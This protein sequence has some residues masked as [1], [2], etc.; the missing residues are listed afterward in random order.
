M[1][2]TLLTPDFSLKWL[3]APQ[4]TPG[5]EATPGEPEAWSRLSDLLAPLERC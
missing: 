2:G 1:N 4:Q 3:N 5:L